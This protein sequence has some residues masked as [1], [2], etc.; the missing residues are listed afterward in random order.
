MDVGS[1]VLVGIDVEAG[2]TEP[3]EIVVADIGAVSFTNGDSSNRTLLI[4]GV[5]STLNPVVF[6]LT[7]CSEDALA[8]E[9]DYL[10]VEV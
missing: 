6:E 3:V 7:S 5:G 4:N 8:S 9:H 2:A 10:A 1:L